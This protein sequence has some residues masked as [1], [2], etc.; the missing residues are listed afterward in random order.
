MTV[1][2]RP[3]LLAPLV[4]ALAFPAVSAAQDAV[5]PPSESSASPS[6][7]EPRHW[8]LGG[9]GEIVGM[10]V[11]ETPTEI[12]IDIGPRIIGIPREAVAESKSVSELTAAAAASGGPVAGVGER[13]ESSALLTQN[14]IVDRAKQSVVLISNPRGAGSGF[15]LDTEGRI[16][17]NH[18]VV[19]N[20]RWQTVNMFRK[21]GAQWERVK[22]EN[23]EV[24][25]FSPLYDI[26]IVRLPMEEV[27]KAGI[28]LVP[29]PIAGADSLQVGDPVYAIGNPGMGGRM[30]EHS[31]SEGIASS[32][33]RNFGDI[34]YI[35]TTA[36]VNPGNSGGPLVNRRGEVVGLVTLKAIFQEGIAFALP[37][38]LMHHFLSTSESFAY[39]DQTGSTGFRYL[40]PEQ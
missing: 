40:P 36:A 29:M 10:L 31:V 7:A 2:L 19:R 15:V 35:Q 23:A 16:V 25:A 24:E 21:R 1:S 39:S 33:A 37:S 14:E 17:T 26:A 38:G 34:I 30:L 22:L 28:E 4:A 27:E 32:L 18:H 20:E 6:P 3:F 5:A 11:K 12:F 13:A 9:G 8:A